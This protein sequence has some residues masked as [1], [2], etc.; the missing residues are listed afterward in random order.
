[1]KLSPPTKKQ[2]DEMTLLLL[3][4]VNVLAN[5]FIWIAEKNSNIAK[6]L[7]RFQEQ[8]LED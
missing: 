7:L 8:L 3:E 1:M 6:S 2:G 5:L 4:I